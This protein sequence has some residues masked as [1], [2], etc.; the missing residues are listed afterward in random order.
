MAS[1]KN[2]LITGLSAPTKQKYYN[3]LVPQLNEAI[4]YYNTPTGIIISFRSLPQ[5]DECLKRQYETKELKCYPP[6]DVF[7][8]SGHAIPIHTL[9]SLKEMW[10]EAIQSPSQKSTENLIKFL[11]AENSDP[12]ITTHLFIPLLCQLIND[13]I[14]DAINKVFDHLLDS[15]GSELKPA[16]TRFKNVGIDITHRNKAVMLNFL[17]SE[18]MSTIGNYKKLFLI[19]K[20]IK[21]KALELNLPKKVIFGYYFKSNSN[22]ELQFSFDTHILPELTTE[23]LQILIQEE[24]NKELKT[25]LPRTDLAILLIQ[26]KTRIATSATFWPIFLIALNTTTKNEFQNF[27]SYLIKW[28]TNYYLFY[29]LSLFITIILLKTPL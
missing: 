20:K 10:V 25:A 26:H 15:P 18:A 27:G 28:A 14:E 9:T 16:I 1:Y 22:G 17:Y 5:L 3:K 2:K 11:T 13:N 21:E 4:A 19:V 29:I 12:R 8:H 7:G 6:I 24:T 23:Q